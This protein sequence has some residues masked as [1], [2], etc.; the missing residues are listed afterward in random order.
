MEAFYRFGAIKGGVN[1]SDRCKSRD[2]SHNTIRHNGAQAIGAQAARPLVTQL[3]RESYLC[4]HIVDNDCQDNG[5]GIVLFGG[6]GPA[7]DNVLDGMVIGNHI[8]GTPRHA[9]RVIGGV[10]FGGYAAQRNRVR[11]TMSRNHIAEAG[12]VPIFLQGGIAEGQE[13]V[14]DNTVVA[15]LLANDLP[16]VSGKLS[17]LLNDGLAGNAVH[18][19][20]PAPAHTRTSDP[21]P[22]Q[23]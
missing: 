18:V 21:L 22:Y 20:D 23:A 13:T 1:L 11:L 17:V 5:E 3:I 6:F 10:G 14:T 7:E 15:Q 2:V 12:E 19:E 9:V 8:T 16:V 4:L